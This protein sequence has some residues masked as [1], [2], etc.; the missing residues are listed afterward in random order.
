MTN[1]WGFLLQTISVSLVILLILLVKRIFNDKLSARFQYLIWTILALRILI[2]ANILK[3]TLI[4]FSLTLETL[5]SITEKGLSSVYASRFEPITLS[6][7]FPIIEEKP[8]SITDI[9]FCIYTAGIIL[10][11]LYYLFSYLRLRF[12]LFHEEKPTF[13][14]QENIDTIANIHGLNSCKIRYVHGISSA[15]VCGIIRP[16]LI[17]PADKETDEK[18]ILHELLHLRYK[19]ALQNIF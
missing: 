15:F 12:L 11:L 5:K 2:P 13:E 1:I 17:L 10:Y 9:L 18:I 14:E 6:S 3:T 16:L 8:E 19:D 4:P 7:V